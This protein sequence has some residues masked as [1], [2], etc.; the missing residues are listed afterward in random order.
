M[1]SKE[2]NDCP[3]EVGK[4]AKKSYVS[5]GACFTPKTWECSENLVSGYGN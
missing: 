1:A 3:Q 5:E 4:D 2:E